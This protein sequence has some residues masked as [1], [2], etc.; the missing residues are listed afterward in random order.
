MDVFYPVLVEVPIAMN[1]MI[2][3]TIPSA[4]LPPFLTPLG[5]ENRSTNGEFVLVGGRPDT[6]VFSF[7]T[8]VPANQAKLVDHFLYNSKL[9]PSQVSL[10]DCRVADGYATYVVPKKVVSKSDAKDM[11][12]AKLRRNESRITDAVES[13]PATVFSAIVT[14]VSHEDDDEDESLFVSP[15]ENLMNKHLENWV[16]KCYGDNFD[17]TGNVALLEQSKLTIHQTSRPDLT[18]IPKSDAFS[19]IS[20][21]I[22]EDEYDELIG[23]A[24]E[25]KMNDNKKAQALANMLS[26]AG[27][28]AY[29]ALLHGKKFYKINIFGLMCNYFHESAHLL[30]L[31]LNFRT[32]LSTITEYTEPQPIDYQLAAAI[33]LVR[34]YTSPA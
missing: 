6:Y 1:D 9:I 32:R 18:L 11:I 7:E 10:P 4:I 30:C 16:R 27:L 23:V 19:A 25:C 28:L 14:I 24:G 8:T 5:A 29:R 31:K 15:V 22:D 17:I 13:A 20:V 33:S 3:A 34:Q 2:G 21:T 26:V 12:V